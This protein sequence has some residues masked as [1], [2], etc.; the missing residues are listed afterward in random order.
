MKAGKTPGMVDVP[1]LSG[2]L[3]EAFGGRRDSSVD[4]RVR[5]FLIARGWMAPSVLEEC[6]HERAD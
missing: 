5:D 6:A 4:G 1:D 2:L 3:H